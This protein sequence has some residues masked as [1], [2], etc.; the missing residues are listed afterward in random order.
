MITAEGTAGGVFARKLMLTSGTGVGH[1]YATSW[2]Y[3]YTE[4]VTPGGSGHWPTVVAVHLAGG[5]F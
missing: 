3:D 2:T 4:N 1:V 5:K